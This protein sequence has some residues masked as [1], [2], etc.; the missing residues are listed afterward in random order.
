M[1]KLCVVYSTCFHH[2]F[3]ISTSCNGVCKCLCVFKGKVLY[4]NICM[5]PRA[6]EVLFL[7]DSRFG[8]G[9]PVLWTHSRYGS[10]HTAH[11]PG[12][13]TGEQ[14]HIYT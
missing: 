13:A 3:D 4:M 1:T 9:T 2:N 11:P 5:N 12:K 8:R 14:N 6:T 7:P 10:P